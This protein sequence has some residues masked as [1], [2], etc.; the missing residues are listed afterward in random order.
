MSTRLESSESESPAE[1]GERIRRGGGGDAGKKRRNRR[2][3][4][5]ERRRRQR[6]RWDSTGPHPHHF[7]FLSSYL[8]H[9]AAAAPHGKQLN[10]QEAFSQ[11]DRVRMMMMSSVSDVLD[12]LEFF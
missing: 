9:T 8:N 5:E 10:I 12:K 2:R 7:V 4:K 11:D 3:K 1:D 6:R